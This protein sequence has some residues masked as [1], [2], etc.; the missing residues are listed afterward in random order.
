[1]AFA[2]HR[3]VYRHGEQFVSFHLWKKMKVQNV[4]RVA[5]KISKETVYIKL[6]SI[7][8]TNFLAEECILNSIK[9]EEAAIWKKT[10]ILKHP[11]K[12]FGLSCFV[13]AFTLIGISRGCNYA[14]NKICC[15]ALK[16]Y[17]T[18]C[19][20]QNAFFLIEKFPTK[21]THCVVVVPMQPTI[22]SGCGQ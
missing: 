11:Y 14:S 20:F 6:S 17:S 12:L 8:K 7:K 2:L 5:L 9:A 19:N 3:A 15:F 1:M 18:W 10:G 21:I 22:G 16:Q 13:R 4:W